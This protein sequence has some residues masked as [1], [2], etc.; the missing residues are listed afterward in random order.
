MVARRC[1]GWVGVADDVDRR[2]MPR[3]DHAAVDRRQRPA[4]I[5]VAATRSP[6]AARSTREP[7]ALAEYGALRRIDRTNDL[8]LQ[9]DGSPVSRLT[10]RP[11]EPTLDRLYAELQLPGFGHRS[12]SDRPAVRAAGRSRGRRLLRRGARVRPRRERAAVDRAA[13]GDHGRM[14]P[15]DYVRRVRSAAAGR[16]RISQ[17]RAPLDARRRPRRAAVAAAADARPR[18]IDRG[19]FLEGYDP[20]APR[21]SAR[22]STASRR[23]RWRWICRRPTAACRAAGRLLLLPAPVGGQRL[24]AAEPVPALD[25][26]PRRA[27]SR[28]L[29]ARARRPR[30]SCRS[31]RTSSASG[32]ACG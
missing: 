26:A 30:W 4:Q 23:A 2:G 7:I 3:H 21:M 22:R 1:A 19:F 15:A 31:T 20:G 25:G 32:R 10:L 8:P 11:A 27:R 16:R 24:Q 17:L 28:R 9:V 5:D 29:D 12:D 6:R 14:R 18:R 13:A